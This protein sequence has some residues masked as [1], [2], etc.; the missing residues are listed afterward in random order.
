[1]EYCVIYGVS[2]MDDIKES[3]DISPTQERQY[4]Y[5]VTWR[6]FR[7]TIVAL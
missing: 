3:T 1:M 2:Y 7:V 4:K 6:R 5:N